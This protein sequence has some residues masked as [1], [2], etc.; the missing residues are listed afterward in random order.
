M[1]TRTQKSP[2]WHGLD[3]PAHL[4][5]I[6]QSYQQWRGPLLILGIAAVV[7]YGLIASLGFCNGYWQGWATLVNDGAVDFAVKKGVLAPLPVASW[8]LALNTASNLLSLVSFGT[9]FLFTRNMF[10]S[11]G[12]FTSA[13]QYFFRSLR[14]GLTA[15]GTIFLMFC[16]VIPIYFGVKNMA[17][18]TGGFLL[19]YILASF[20]FLL[21]GA[22]CVYLCLY[23]LSV[24]T[25]GSFRAYEGGQPGAAYRDGWH[26]FKRHWSFYI[27]FFLLTAL[28]LAVNALALHFVLKLVGCASTKLIINGVWGV[29]GKPF[30]Y[31]TL[32][33]QVQYYFSI[34]H[35][36]TNNSIKE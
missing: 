13:S 4:E 32:L 19:G 24:V 8:Q 22:L 16:T 9:V 31:L 28:L 25:F 3:L 14:V 29:L 6:R 21:G 36:L 35:E 17:L 7:F 26:L 34:R 15:A 33:I 30:W 23:M 2:F 10:R 27:G 1:N 12:R 5:T 11:V 18:L 20:L